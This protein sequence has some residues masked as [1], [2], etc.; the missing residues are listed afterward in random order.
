MIGRVPE[1]AIWV[2]NRYNVG[3]SAIRHPH[4][5]RGSDAQWRR[6]WI[7]STHSRTWHLSLAPVDCIGSFSLEGSQKSRRVSLVSDCI[8]DF[9]VCVPA[10]FPISYYGFIAYQDFVINAYFRLLLGI[11]FSLQVVAKTPEFDSV[12]K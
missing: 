5:V 3:W 9:L 11:L 7:W 8:C 6:K 12:K 10:C 1:A 2:W 4:H